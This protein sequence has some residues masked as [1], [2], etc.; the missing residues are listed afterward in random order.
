MPLT[1]INLDDRDFEQ[2][3]SDAKE[4]ILQSGSQWTDL[5]PGDP[6]TVLL[7]L[8]AYLT[9]TMIYRLNR[10]PEKA[11]V[12]FL[13][14]IGVTLTAPASAGATLLFTLSRPSSNPV[15][16]PQNTRVTVARAAG[17]SSAPVFYTLKRAVINPGDREVK[18]AACHC[19]PVEA[20]LAG[21]G[22]GLPGQT[23][24][25]KQPPFAQNLS[26]IVGIET[27]EAEIKDRSASM[28]FKDKAYRI[29]REVEYFADAGTDRYVYVVDRTD[30][31]VRFAPALRS[32]EKSGTLAERAQALAEVAPAGREIRL[33]Y[34]GGGG[35]AGNVAAGSLTL[36][37]DPVPGVQITVTN[38][39]A[40]TGGT[41]A[42]TVENAM[43]RGPLQLRSLERAVTADDFELIAKQSSGAICRAKAFTKARYWKHAV[44]GTVE[45]LLVPEVPQQEWKEGAVP[46]E[47]L[48]AREA[49]DA[50]RAVGENI[51]ER[52]PLGTMCEVK[53]VNYKQVKVK[54][55]VVVNQGENPDALQSRVLA[56]LHQTIN[57]VPTPFQPSGWKFGMPLRVS[58]VYDIILSEPGVSYADQVRLLVEEV[59]GADVRAV[60]PDAHQEDM[61]YAICDGDVFRSVNSGDGWEKIAGFNGGEIITLKTHPQKPGLLALNVRPANGDPGSSIYISEDCGEHWNLLSG[62]AFE[63][64]SVAWILRNNAPVLFLAADN[65]LYEVSTDKGSTPVQILVAPENQNLGFYAIETV[66]DVRGTAFVAVAAQG[67]GGIYLSNQAGKSKSFTK[68]GLENED[69][70]VLVVQ[71]DGPRSFLWA[72]ITV[73]GNET[74][75]GCRRWELNPSADSPGGWKDP[76]PGWSGGS[77]RS[78]SF[79]GSFA[80][81]ASFQAGIAVLD[82]RKKDASWTTSAIDCGLPTRDKVRLF[83]PVQAA[84]RS[85]EGSPLFIACKD[86]IYRSPDMIKFAKCSQNE[87]IEQITLPHSWIFCSGRHE[88]EVIQ[89]NEA[90]SD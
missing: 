88:I 12:E 76:G 30:G 52:R 26:L 3:M 84:S 48:K 5:S 77:C 21:T 31:I 56:R 68:I 13:R 46:L 11:Y 90:R 81:A 64:E 16:I 33:W 69:V 85:D 58:H 63:V 32:L 45:V 71:Q 7:E 89:E 55:R 59:P 22:T 47:V 74:G 27:P 29:W 42:E 38:P 24:R 44:A 75:K 37:R 6:G 9:E 14:L 87:F 79:V 54:A 19:E 80:V 15:E 83:E 17:N 20:E 10:L 40:A 57:P 49:G 66:T 1:P 43:L 39:E 2:L 73:A 53:W 50:I 4:K 28:R 62:T 41:E 35:P 82:L 86:G 25:A 67:K 51:D 8:F 60:I 72:G 34:Y 61:Y 36:L 70:R 65:G 18:V 23:V 78:I